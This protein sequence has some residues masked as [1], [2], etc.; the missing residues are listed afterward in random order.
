MSHRKRNKKPRGFSEPW[1]KPAY[2]L[3]S[4][5]LDVHG[6]EKRQA[7]NG[8][9]LS[10]AGAAALSSAF[11]GCFFAI[12]KGGVGIVPGWLIGLVVAVI[13]FNLVMGWLKADRYYRP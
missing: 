12:E 7:L 9:S 5:M 6:P 8:V 4:D 1:S 2:D 10:I 3:F 11:G 13:V